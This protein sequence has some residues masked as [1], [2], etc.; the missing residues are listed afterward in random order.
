MTQE[1]TLRD[2]AVQVKLLNKAFAH[3]EAE[4]KAELAMQSQGATV[5]LNAAAAKITDIE[6]QL[7]VSRAEL[8]QLH[9]TATEQD[10]RLR[11][12]AVE[13]ARASAEQ[14]SNSEFLSQQLAQQLAVLK[15][16][17]Q[18][19]ESELDAARAL[20]KS[21]VAHAAEREQELRAAQ[22]TSEHAVSAAEARAA[23]IEARCQSLT[24]QIA[25]AAQ[26]ERSA[27]QAL[28]E[29]HKALAAGEARS[30]SRE[31]T[32]LEKIQ[33]LEL[34]AE[35]IRAE[36]ADQLRAANQALRAA[37]ERYD[38]DLAL[39]QSKVQ[40]QQTQ[41]NRVAAQREAALAQL[42]VLQE[43]NNQLQAESA[44]RER[45]LTAQV[46]QAQEKAGAEAQ[47]RAESL[48]ASEAQH[49][50][51]LR[52]LQAELL[53]LTDRGQLQGDSLQAQ[54]LAAHEVNAS[55]ERESA[56]RE[57]LLR[58]DMRA[59]L[60]VALVRADANRAA[61]Q[62]EARNYLAQLAERD[63]LH[64][65]ER[66][67]S[68]S[69]ALAA[70]QALAAL[71]V[72]CDMALA[73]L[74]QARQQHL[75]L[76]AQAEQ[77][78]QQLRS[79]QSQLQAAARHELDDARSTWAVQ[80]AEHL[81]QI[82]SLTMA[83]SAA[84][85]EEAQL[86]ATAARELEALRTVRQSAS[87]ELAEQ[88]LE[89]ADSLALVAQLQQEVEKLRNPVPQAS[90]D[91]TP[92]PA[93]HLAAEPTDPPA[94]AAVDQP[95]SPPMTTYETAHTELQHISQ[96]MALHGA[97][98]VTAAYRSVL[99]RDPDPHGAAYYLSR[100]DTDHDRPAM[101][102][103]LAT[104]AEGRAR[105][106]SLSGLDELVASRSTAR[107]RLRQWLNKFFRIE[108]TSTR[109]E[110]ALAAA[111]K[112]SEERLPVLDNKL[113]QIFQSQQQL[114]ARLESRFQ[115]LET[116]LTLVVA[117][118][119]PLH[120]SLSAGLASHERQN[121]E[122]MIGLAERLSAGQHTQTLIAERLRA[123]EDMLIA[124][125]QRASADS[126]GPAAPAGAAGH[127]PAA[128]A[129]AH[130]ALRALDCKLDASQGAQS[131]IQSLASQLANS[132]EAASLSTR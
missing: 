110:R 38:R 26:R 114:D 55:A 62:Q 97:A 94:L 25:T 131:L 8:M 74:A 92:M 16:H 23:Q 19:L 20:H 34:Q 6:S 53:A 5:A 2:W 93:V 119:Q 82:Q 120:E 21:A 125:A 64:A 48:A 68:E 76:Q 87:T 77:R 7:L 89:L 79:E 90:P 30:H 117:S 96:L 9:Q 123:C 107:G 3:R 124:S 11:D 13:E 115:V 104:S 122:S 42:G 27:R 35:Q 46:V 61:Q 71:Q 44:A 126:V 63:G 72:R 67:D 99:G 40:E 12:A 100:L 106:Q 1:G 101:L 10:A 54:L 49:S 4:L 83:L 17:V 86:R 56:D 60:Q 78:E 132:A 58:E 14:V 130:A 85:D 109:I 33:A 121:A 22:A 18:A 51:R 105:R 41:S 66:R 47:Q 80:Q 103:E 15:S 84:R 108:Q 52:T 75:H 31:S 37:Q 118:L 127:T 112:Q 111:G 50:E 65:S 59:M 24:N 70:A 32:Q 39:L 43:A 128:A 73:E 98:F 57:R 91:R 129:A 102:Y 28:D 36:H 69:R 88:R 45:E 116:R 113:A 95:V 29:A 81:Q